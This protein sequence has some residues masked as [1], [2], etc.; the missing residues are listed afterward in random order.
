MQGLPERS[1][2]TWLK[3]NGW[4]GTTTLQGNQSQ[5][6]HSQTSAIWK[7]PFQTLDH[8]QG[9]RREAGKKMVTAERRALFLQHRV[10]QHPKTK[11]TKT[12]LHLDLQKSHEIRKAW[13]VMR[14]P[15]TKKMWVKHRKEVIETMAIPD[16]TEGFLLSRR[17]GQ[18]TESSVVET[19]HSAAS[20]LRLHAS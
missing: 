10:R 15:R 1:L 5:P 19:V 14:F 3:K 17:G 4:E 13:K 16:L 8:S 20:P 11:G 18:T 9:R 2:Q 7:I 6:H 12:S